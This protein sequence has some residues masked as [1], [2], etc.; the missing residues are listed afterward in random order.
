MLIN[1]LI[2]HNMF[3]VVDKIG[4]NVLVFFPNTSIRASRYLSLE[5][6]VNVLL[7][8][9]N[10]CEQTSPPPSCTDIELCVNTPGGFTCMC[11]PGYRKKTNEGACEGICNLNVVTIIL[12]YVVSG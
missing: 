12:C 5:Q 8:D 4:A 2:P 1:Q 10:E 3:D 11:K 9:V 7:A 6:S